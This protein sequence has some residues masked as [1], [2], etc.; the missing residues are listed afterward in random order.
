MN[1]LFANLPNIADFTAGFRAAIPNITP[2]TSLAD[3]V[4]SKFFSVGLWEVVASGLESSTKDGKTSYFIPVE[5]A[6]GRTGRVF[7][8]PYDRKTGVVQKYEIQRLFR[9]FGFDV[10]QA[11]IVLTDAENKKDPNVT[12]IL[13]YISVFCRGKVGLEV[14]W[15]APHAISPESGSWILVDK[16]GNPGPYLGLGGEPEGFNSYKD[17]ENFAK[18]VKLVKYYESFPKMGLVPSP[19]K[20]EPAEELLPYYT[21]LMELYGAVVKGEAPPPPQ[22]VAAPK[23]PAWVK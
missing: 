18:T 14:K 7:V 4:Q 11:V 10:P 3:T 17:V 21:A 1:P 15:T 9:A 16:D 22:A 19:T 5:D 13:E 8:N 12:G 20:S 2:G 6:E 23:K